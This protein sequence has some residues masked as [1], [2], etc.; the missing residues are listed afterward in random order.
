MVFVNRDPDSTIPPE[1][2]KGRSR[3][4]SM[5]LSCLSVAILTILVVI[6]LLILS[7]RVSPQ[8][9]T[10]TVIVVLQTKIPFTPTRTTPPTSSPIPLTVTAAGSKTAIPIPP[11]P[12]TPPLPLP[13]TAT[14]ISFKATSTSSATTVGPVTANDQWLP[15]FSDFGD[16]TMVMVPPG[17]FMMGS[18]ATQI[19][20]LI[21]QAPD[22]ADYFKTE[23][24]Q[25]KVCFDAPFWIDKTEVTQA[26]FKQFGGQAAT[27][28]RFLDGYLPV[29]NITWLEAQDF[30][31][32]RGGRLPTEAEW[33]YAARG[34]DDLI[35]PWGNTFIADNVIDSRAFYSQTDYVGTRPAG[36]SWVGALDMSGNVWEWTHTIYDETKFPYP[37]NKDDGRENDLDV[38]SQHVLRS[39]S[40]VVT[41]LVVRT[42][43]RGTNPTTFSLTSVGFR[44]ARSLAPSRSSL[45]TLTPIPPTAKRQ[46]AVTAIPM[47][48]QTPRRFVINGTSIA[49]VTTNN[50]WTPQF[51]DFDGVTMTL[52]PPGCF[53]MGS[54]DTQ[55]T[56]L[57][58]VK[59][60]VWVDAFE[61]EGPQTPICFDTPFW[62]DKI[63][64]SQKQFKQFKGQAER[65]PNDV[66]DNR[67]VEN[68][69]WLEGR[70][71]CAKRGGRLPTEA[72]WEY[73]ARG[74][75]D[76]IY[77]WGNTFVADNVVHSGS[78]FYVIADVGTKPA[79]ASWVGALDMSGNVAE[80]TNTIY[81]QSNFPYPYNKDDGRESN[82]DTLSFRTVRGSA[83]NELLSF[84]DLFRSAMRY[85]NLPAYG[86]IDTGIRCV[87]AY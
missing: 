27:R 42:P 6:G 24:P 52:V 16:V 79:G 33:E 3:R 60:S 44:C 23:G 68:I 1:K 45:P 85:R 15:R 82:E 67:P 49:Q 2:R 28:P 47:E 76:L 86:H 36:A 55:I 29:D 17:C 59:M 64:V 8:P 70:A 34:P 31:T 53:V 37:Y 18:T 75:D 66:G 57:I 61:S 26:Q 10:P 11:L 69:S 25:A 38:N 72:E 62:I 65:S 83:W 56:Q 48:S 43:Y 78:S 39:G 81:D 7:R 84:D 14:R 32:K 41:N 5:L 63:E 35:Y 12:T 58:Q 51:K 21:R 74:P 9:T 87:R 19:A 20:D 40:L 71:Y 30:C 73:A 77:P 46:A 50:Q 54:T 22:L 80:W 4:A 13:P